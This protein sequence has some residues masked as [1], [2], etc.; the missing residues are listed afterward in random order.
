MPGETYGRGRDEVRR[1]APSAT[2]HSVPAATFIGYN[3]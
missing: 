2:P 1:P 3:E